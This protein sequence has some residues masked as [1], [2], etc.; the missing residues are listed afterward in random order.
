VLWCCWLG[1]RKGIQPLKNW[2]VGFWH[3]NLSGARCKF[4]YDMSLV[5]SF[6]TWCTSSSYDKQCQRLLVNRILPRTASYT[7][8]N[9]ITYH[10]CLHAL[11]LCIH[12]SSEEQHANARWSGNGNA[13]SQALFHY[14]SHDALANH[15]AS[16]PRTSSRPLCTIQQHFIA[17]KQ[18]P[19]C[20]QQCQSH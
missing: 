13:T 1:G 12:D 10:C 7:V 3:G 6:G 16:M 2:V 11:Q 15:S 19:I 18:S 5:S 9:V 4:A 20:K 17:L 8:K 14:R